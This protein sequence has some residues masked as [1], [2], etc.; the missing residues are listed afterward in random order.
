MS[1]NQ[2]DPQYKLRMPLELKE[3]I[4][5]SAKAHN[6]SIN[7][8]IVLRLEESFN[9][10]GS[11]SGRK[12]D[13]KVITMGEN[14]IRIISGKLINVV[15]VDYSQNLTA[16]RKSIELALDTLK[17]SS[18]KHWLVTAVK[19]VIVYQGHNHI[20]IIDNGRGSL[21]WLIVEDHYI[22]ND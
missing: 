1:I 14:K 6:R 15:D 4:A 21:N 2:T 3:K 5:N 17:R 13:V 12:A 16:L 9:A 11:D 20:D 7:A 22:S 10:Q 8:D 18:I 19:D